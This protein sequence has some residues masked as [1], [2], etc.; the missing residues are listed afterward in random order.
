MAV[1][2]VKYKW[3]EIG[4]STDTFVRG[5]LLGLLLG[6]GVFTVAYS[7]EIIMLSMSGNSPSLSFYVTSY[8]IEGSRVMQDGVLFILICIL[9][10][11]I[12]VVMEE[13]VFR[14]LF[15]R[16]TREKYS[17]ALACVLS[18]LLFGFW[19]IA[20]PVRNVLDGEQS[21]PGALMM[22]LM[23]VVASALIGVQY[24]ML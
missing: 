23:L 18:S 1:R 7:V 21:I 14:G 5:T 24:V 2:F 16:M 12:N 6:G 15:V 8:A 19:H 9:G 11:I 10:N 3:C 4:L 13:G 22:G 17:F 20:Q